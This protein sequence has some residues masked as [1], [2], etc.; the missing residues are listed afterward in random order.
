MRW[1]LLLALFLTSAASAR[2]LTPFQEWLSFTQGAAFNA[3]GPIGM[4]AAQDMKEVQPGESLHLPPAKTPA[5]LRWSPTRV[6]KPILTISYKDSRAIVSGP[7]IAATDLLK[8]PGRQMTLANQLTV[9]ATSLGRTTLKIWLYNPALVVQ[10][11][12]RG[13]DFFPYDPKAMTKATF[14]QNAKPTPV[15]YLDSRDHAG[16]MY[17]VGQV[18]LPF[19]GAIHTLR[20][21]SYQ[22]NWADIE[23]LLLLFKDRTSG[24]TTYG[25]GRVIELRIPKGTPP[26]SLAVDLNRAYSFSCAHSEFYNCPL[27]LTDRLGVAIPHGEKYPPLLIP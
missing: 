13:L 25:G 14:A 2:E 6:A 12:F 22:S 9:R 18:K 24:K 15:N 7:G 11:G 23:T 21:Y 19:A 17:V 3:A 1:I 5:L 20:A 27:A 16:T 10:R 4:Y 8:Q 26:K